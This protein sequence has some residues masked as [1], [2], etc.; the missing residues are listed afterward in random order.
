MD[1]KGS[2]AV[3]MSGGLKLLLVCL[4]E[5]TAFD[6]K[7]NLQWIVSAEW[8]CV[9]PPVLMRGTRQGLI[10]VVVFSTRIHHEGFVYVIIRL[11]VLVHQ[12]NIHTCIRVGVPRK[13]GLI[14]SS[15]IYNFTKE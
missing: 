9:L 11:A 15:D 12:N 8:R 5:N 3:C 1:W 10:L 7:V 2:S 14:V 6:S 4:D 13:H